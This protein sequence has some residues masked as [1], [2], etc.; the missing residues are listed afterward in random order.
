M[1]WNTLAAIGQIVSAL[2]VVIT[3]VYIAIQ[4]RHAR[5][6]QRAD[7][8]RTNRTERRDFFTAA[9]DSQFM[10]LILAKLQR[11]ESLDPEEQ[12]R[13]MHHNAA[14]W[15]L[16]YSE[17]ISDQLKLPGPYSTDHKARLEFALNSPGMIKWFDKYGRRLYPAEF[18]S[19][20]EQEIQQFREVAQ[21]AGS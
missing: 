11:A 3:L 4:V 17:W 16:L 1:N 20:V 14:L 15:G 18:V 19:Q 2:A 5:E 21:N 12:I 8:I 7:A 10:P 13:L 6:S 9:R